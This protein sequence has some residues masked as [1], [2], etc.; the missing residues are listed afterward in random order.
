[1]NR[2]DGSEQQHLGCERLTG[3]AIILKMVSTGMNEGIECL[4]LRQ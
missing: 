1:M 2:I 3:H 4:Q